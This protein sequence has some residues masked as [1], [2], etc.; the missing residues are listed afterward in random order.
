MWLCILHL[1]S[2]AYSL[3]RLMSA[4]L[5]FVFCACSIPSPN[6]LVTYWL[7]DGCVLGWLQKKI[8]MG[9]AAEWNV[10]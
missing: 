8:K 1:V 6:D 9:V 7:A 5:C 3:L 2:V 4:S 10:K